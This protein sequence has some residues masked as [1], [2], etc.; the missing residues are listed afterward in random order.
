LDKTVVIAA[1]KVVLPWSTI[2]GNSIYN[3]VIKDIHPTQ[4]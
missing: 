2:N 4:V 3:L 1:V